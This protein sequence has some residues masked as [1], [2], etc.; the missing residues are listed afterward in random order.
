MPSTRKGLSISKRCSYIASGATAPIR[1]TRCAHAFHS[2]GP[3]S[4]P[5]L[6]STSETPVPLW[7]SMAWAQLSIHLP[8]FDERCFRRATSFDLALSQGALQAPLRGFDHCSQLSQAHFPVA[9]SNAS[10]FIFFAGDSINFVSHS[11]SL[12]PLVYHPARRIL[13]K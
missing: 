9:F 5:L 2:P 4:I 12:S 13:T 1:Q 6:A 11:L 7:S 10:Q 3:C 8:S